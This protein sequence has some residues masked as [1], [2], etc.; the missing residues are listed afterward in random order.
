MSGFRRRITYHFQ[1]QASRFQ[2]Y[3][4]YLILY[5]FSELMYVFNI[6]RN[7][8]HIGVVEDAK[9]SQLKMSNLRQR[10]SH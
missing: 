4:P 7:L 3:N 8:S 9:Y 10:L 5:L 2:R 6:K 1:V